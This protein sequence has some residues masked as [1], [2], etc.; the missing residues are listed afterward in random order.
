M[1][2]KIILEEDWVDMATSKQVSNGSN[3]RVTGIRVM[4]FNFGGVSLIA[5]GEMA[6]SVNFVS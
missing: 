3:Q 2:K 1:G 6:P 4:G 5:I